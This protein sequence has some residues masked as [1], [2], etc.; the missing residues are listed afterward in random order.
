MS[1]H[2]GA[3]VMVHRP[4]TVRSISRPMLALCLAAL[5]LAARASE[6]TCITPPATLYLAGDSTLAAK[7][8]E[9]RPE[10]GW[11]EYLAAQFREGCVRIDNRAQRPQHANLR[12]GRALA[13]VAG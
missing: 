13:G 2:A 12:R 7:A 6:S 11:G 5:A 4:V 8:P 10:A 1:P 9:K 3:R